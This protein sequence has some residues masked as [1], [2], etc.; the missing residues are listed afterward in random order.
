MKIIILLI[1]LISLGWIIGSFAQVPGI[2]VQPYKRLVLRWK[3]DSHSR[4]QDN[5]ICEANAACPVG[6]LRPTGGCVI[7]KTSLCYRGHCNLPILDCPTDLSVEVQTNVSLCIGN[8]TTRKCDGQNITGSQSVVTNNPRP[9]TLLNSTKIHNRSTYGTVI[10]WV[11]KPQHLDRHVV[12]I[13][14][15]CTPVANAVKHTTVFWTILF[16]PIPKCRNKPA[17]Y[18]TYKCDKQV[19]ANKLSNVG[20]YSHDALQ[21]L[22]RWM[23]SR[24][25]SQKYQAYWDVVSARILKHSI[26]DFRW[27]NVSEWLNWIEF[28]L[29]MLSAKMQLRNVQQTIMSSNYNAWKEL[30]KINKGYWLKG[31][32]HFSVFPLPPS[33]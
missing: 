18:D 1:E 26:N 22:G 17:W 15:T 8:Y 19:T 24:I 29:N 6:I 33:P 21:K 3:S 11:S 12:P 9:L 7:Y 4:R 10:P 31:E 14:H 28:N 13:P 25:Y 23:P 20:R 16:P 5:I 2:E 30:W 32:S 27:N